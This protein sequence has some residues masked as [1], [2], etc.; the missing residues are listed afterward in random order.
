MNRLKVSQE[1]VEALDDLP[2]RQSAATGA[3]VIVKP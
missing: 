2:E 1:A 3:I